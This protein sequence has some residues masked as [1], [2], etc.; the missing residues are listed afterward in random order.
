VRLAVA[1][2]FVIGASTA[3]IMKPIMA[4]HSTTR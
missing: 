3:K 2:P 1:K 4:S